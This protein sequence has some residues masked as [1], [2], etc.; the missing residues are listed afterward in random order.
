MREQIGATGGEGRAPPDAAQAC[1]VDLKLEAG[2]LFGMAGP[3]RACPPGTEPKGGGGGGG[4]ACQICWPGTASAGGGAACKRCSN[5][6][7]FAGASH[8]TP[9]CSNVAAG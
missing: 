9:G 5:P 1:R 2:R 6:Q 3:A 4:V 8:L 7:G